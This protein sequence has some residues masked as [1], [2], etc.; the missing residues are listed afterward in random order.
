VLAKVQRTCILFYLY[1][2]IILDLAIRAFEQCA[3]DNPGGIE[4]NAL[5]LAKPVNLPQRFG[6]CF[7]IGNVNWPS[8]DFYGPAGVLRC[9]CNCSFVIVALVS[10]PRKE[11][12]LSMRFAG[13]EGP[14]NGG[15]YCVRC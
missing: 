15:I 7:I 12:Y 4:E 10:A 6:E 5:N 2:E 1:L 14:G 13:A 3:G 9:F 11:G 8:L